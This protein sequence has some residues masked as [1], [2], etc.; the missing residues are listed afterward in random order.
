M[1]QFHFRRTSW[2]LSFYDKG[3]FH[4]TAVNLKLTPLCAQSDVDI[5]LV[6]LWRTDNC[7]LWMLPQ[8]ESR[9]WHKRLLEHEEAALP[10]TQ[11]VAEP[12]IKGRGK[13]NFTNWEHD[14]THNLSTRLSVS[15]VSEAFCCRSVGSASRVTNLRRKKFRTAC[16]GFTPSLPPETRALSDAWARSGTC[17]E[18]CLGVC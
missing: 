8:D 11:C 14:V 2:F 12:G 9:N 7:L 4:Y 5:P 13:V 15:K 18:T 3:T 1:S 6:A 17:K 10:I 16:L